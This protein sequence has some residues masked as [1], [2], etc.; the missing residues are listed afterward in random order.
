MKKLLILPIILLFAFASFSGCE[1]DEFDDLPCGD[2]N[3][4]PLWKESEG[5]CYWINKDG[6][7]VYVQP[8]DCNCN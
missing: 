3:G 8:A 7:K 4:E 1:K 6:H 5:R 2:Y